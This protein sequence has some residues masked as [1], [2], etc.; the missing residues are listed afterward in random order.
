MSKTKK[1]Y[2]SVNTSKMSIRQAEQQFTLG[3]GYYID[4]L[5]SAPIEQLELL[6]LMEEKER[7]TE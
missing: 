7:M 4:H 1:C 3:G 6:K 5:P 2:L